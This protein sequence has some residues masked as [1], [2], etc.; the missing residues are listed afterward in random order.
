[1]QVQGIAPGIY[2]V[3]LTTDKGEQAIQR[4]IVIN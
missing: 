4:L 1:V 2:L 3:A